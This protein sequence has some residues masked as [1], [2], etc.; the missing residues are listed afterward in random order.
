MKGETRVRSD[1]PVTLVGGG[2]VDL[3]DLDAALSLA[4]MLVAAD[5]GLDHL[6]RLGHMPAAV[7]GDMDSITPALLGS[8]LGGGGAFH[9]ISEQDS[10]DFQ[11]CLRSIAAPLLIGLGFLG[12]RTDHTLAAMNALVT[13]GAP[14]LLLGGPDVCLACPPDLR[15][16]L[17]AGTRVSIFPMAPVTGRISEGLRWPV[18]GLALAPGG[19]IG[20]SN[21]ALGGMVRI[22]FDRPGAIVILPRQELGQVA[23]VILSGEPPGAVR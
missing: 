1:R 11:K 13:C 16:D 19:R 5:G 3:S 18:E 15:L 14:V 17:G 8:L 10:T 20:T 4:P 21:Q 22:G 12:G 6:A 7:I 9:P 2:P 23:R